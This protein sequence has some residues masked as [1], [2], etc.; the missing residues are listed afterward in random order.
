LNESKV[1]QSTVVRD[2]EFQAG[3]VRGKK[4]FL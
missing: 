3:I 1:L 4:E 2:R